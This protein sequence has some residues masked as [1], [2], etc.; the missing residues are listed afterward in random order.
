MK[1]GNRIP[2]DLQRMHETETIGI[3]LVLHRRLVHQK[4]DRIMGD[5]QAIEF[6]DHPDGFAASQGAIGQPLMGIGFVN[7]EFDLPAL[8]IRSIR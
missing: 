4:A 5:E 6:L 2:N 7:E 8:V 3:Q 1:F